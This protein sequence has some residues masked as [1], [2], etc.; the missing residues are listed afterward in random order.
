MK[1]LI[2]SITTAVLGF[3]SQN[4]NSNPKELKTITY[5][6]TSSSLNDVIEGYLK[7]KNALIKSDS[8][9]TAQLADAFTKTLNSFTLNEKTAAQK[10]TG[11]QIAELAKKQ[12]KLIVSNAGKLD[13]QRKAFK[14]LSKNIQEL[15]TT[16]GTSQKL[17]VDFCP[18][19]EGGSTWISES[20]EIKNPY[21]GAQM[22]TCGKIKETIE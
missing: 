16:L 2:F 9:Q 4:E 20:K 15:I 12:T 21:Y 7:I 10:A 17:Y 8:Q 11:I 6:Q 22:L 19:Y 1:A 18:M 14:E 5:S 13:K 3:L